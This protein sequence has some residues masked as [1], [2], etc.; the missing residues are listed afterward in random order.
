[1]QN[2]T[3]MKWISPHSIKNE[4]IKKTKNNE[5]VED[6]ENKEPTGVSIWT[7]NPQELV[8]GDIVI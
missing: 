7:K 3:S 6:A 5:A 8:F 1:M 2:K 4:I